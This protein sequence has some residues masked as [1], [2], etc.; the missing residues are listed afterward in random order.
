MYRRQNSSKWAL[1]G[2]W[3][4]SLRPGASSAMQLPGQHGVDERFCPACSVVQGG[5]W[6]Q[7][8]TVTQRQ[9]PV[10]SAR[11]VQRPSL[12]QCLLPTPASC[13]PGQGHCR[14]QLH[15]NAAPDSSR[16]FHALLNAILRLRLIC[17]R[18]AGPPITSL[19]QILEK[20]SHSSCCRSPTSMSSAVPTR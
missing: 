17:L 5:A 4:C 15:C 20:Q 16:T 11:H 18:I 3:L 1:Q 14:A 12:R 9:P 10:R 7:Q 8:A 13:A 2:Q 6:A 19:M